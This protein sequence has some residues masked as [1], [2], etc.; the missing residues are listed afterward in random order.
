[1]P[2]ASCSS[3]LRSD[4]RRQPA[5]DGQLSADRRRRGGTIKGV[6]D[7]LNHILD[8][9]VANTAAQGGT[10]IIP[11]RG[12]LCDTADVASYR[13]M[14][15]MI[16]DRSRDLK[17]KGMTLDQV[18]A[19]RPT[20]DFDGRYGSTTGAGRRTCLCRPST[21]RCNGEDHLVRRVLPCCVVAD[22]E[23][24][25]GRGGAAGPAVSPRQAA[26]FD[27]T[28]YWVSPII[29]DW[30]YRMVIPNKGVFGGI[31]LNAEG[32]KVGNAWDP[33]ADEKA[34]E[35]CRA[36]GAAG[37]HAL[38]G[39]LHITWQDDATL[40]IDTDTGTQTRIFA[41]RASPAGEPDMAGAVAGAVERSPTA[42]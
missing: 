2:T 3:A 22:V 10:W 40:K 12:R 35:Q 21:G 39:R 20:L 42:A 29:E 25:R 30:K 18:R 7:G 13:N 5:V 38:P 24:Q 27:L 37:L 15:V 34:G 8:L 6:I 31:P 36:F 1:M 14:L 19:A 17:K 41:F 26:P 28:G 4:Q 11:G 23:A 16:R 32:Q 9:A 33:A